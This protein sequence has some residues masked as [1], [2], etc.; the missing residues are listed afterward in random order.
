M[1]HPF[2]VACFDLLANPSFVTAQEKSRK[3]LHEHR[4]ENEVIAYHLATGTP[5]KFRSHVLLRRPQLQEP[6]V[7]ARGTT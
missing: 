3:L 5:V 7:P 4:E 6:P 1:V 2:A